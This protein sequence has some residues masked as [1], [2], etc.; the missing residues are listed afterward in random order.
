[1]MG[2][3]RVPSFFLAM[4]FLRAEADNSFRVVGVTFETRLDG[5]QYS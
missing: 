3:A 5:R 2:A 1:M 4:F